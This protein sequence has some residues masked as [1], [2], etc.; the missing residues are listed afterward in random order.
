[1]CI[2]GLRGIDNGAL[3]ARECGVLGIRRKF[4]VALDTLENIPCP[5]PGGSVV[6][7]AAVAVAAAAVA[8]VGVD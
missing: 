6:A 4:G 2:V 8:V 5:A 1:M 7:V 3:V